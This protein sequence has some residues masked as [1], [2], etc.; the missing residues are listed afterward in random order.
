MDRTA[1]GLSHRPHRA[2]RRILAPDE[3]RGP[4][5]DGQDGPGPVVE[6]AHRDRHAPRAHPGG[7]HRLQR[8]RPDQRRPTGAGLDPPGAPPPLHPQGHRPTDRVHREALQRAH[9]RLHRQR[10]LRRCSGLRPADPSTGHRPEVG[11]GRGHGRR[12][13]RV[14]PRRAGTRPPAAGTAGQ[15]PGHHPGLLRRAGGRPTDQPR[16]RPHHRPLPDRGGWRVAAR[17]GG[18]RN[19]QPATGR[20]HRHHLVVDR[21]SPVALRR[22]RGR[23]APDGRRRRRPLGHRRRGTAAL[24]LTGDH[25]PK[26]RR[27]CRVRGRHVQEGRQDP[28]ELPRC[29]P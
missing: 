26:R 13:H 19:V 3:V 29:K 8:R 10:W 20:R 11:R 21:L 27:G 6:V 17:R 25:G 23:P 28:H 7:R 16:R 12:L 9:R 14:G 4:A 2:L 24:L 18:H 22:P 5:G 15:V 1:R